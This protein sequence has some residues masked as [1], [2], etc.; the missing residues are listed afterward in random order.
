[1]SKPREGPGTSKKEYLAQ[2]T[3]TNSLYS[4]QGHQAAHVSAF[5]HPKRVEVRGER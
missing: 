5:G 1:M 3:V 2:S 4:V